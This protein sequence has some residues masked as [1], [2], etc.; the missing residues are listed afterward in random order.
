MK[1]LSLA[2]GAWLCFAVP[3]HA[4]IIRY[5][6]I[7]T[8]STSALV[9]VGDRFTAL[10]SFDPSIPAE[11]YD[12]GPNSPRVTIVFPS[13]DVF[14]SAPHLMPVAS[15]EIDAHGKWESVTV[16]AETFHFDVYLTFFGQ[17]SGATFFLN[18]VNE[19]SASQIAGTSSA[20][21]D[22]GAPLALALLA[23]APMARRSRFRHS[24]P[25]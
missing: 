5:H 22:T 6:G 4:G 12:E 7:V 18:D 11:P 23:I 8:S 15:I 2:F 21:S 19:H 17:R 16:G 3:S 10:A 9:N 13:V 25:R 14:E 1:P 24:R 20:V